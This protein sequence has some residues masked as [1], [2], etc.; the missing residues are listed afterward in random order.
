LLLFAVSIG[1]KIQVYIIKGGGKAMQNYARVGG[2]LS[3][4][5]GG[6]GCLSAILLVFFAILVGVLSSGDILGNHYYSYSS[7]DFAL[8]IVAIIYGVFGFIG[9]LVSILAI[10]GG[11]YGIKKKNWGFALAGSIAGVIAFFPCGVVAVIFTAM[12]KPEFGIP[13]AVRT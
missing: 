4:V 12:G 5:A 2:I 13:P 11:V 7:P 10:I 1:D 9:V 6:L 3:V 8:G